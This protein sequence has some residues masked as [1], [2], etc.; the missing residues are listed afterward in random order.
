MVSPK[1]KGKALAAAM[2]AA[3][4]LCGAAGAFAARLHGESKLDG[5]WCGTGLLHEFRLRLAQ[6]RT[7]VRGTL[8]R[9]ERVRRVF[10]RLEGSTLRTD[11][12][13]AGSLVLQ[14]AGDELLITGGAGPLALAQ[15]QS[16][17]RAQGGS[18]S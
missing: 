8:E 9:K 1:K 4:A 13:K 11:A 15:G 17:E 2:V 7:D 6:D 18:C 16:F 5:L 12:Q 14:V 3:V 10:G